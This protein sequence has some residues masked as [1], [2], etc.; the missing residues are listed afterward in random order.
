[1]WPRTAKLAEG[2]LLGKR[3]ALSRAI[4]LVESTRPDHR[5]Q[6]E[7]LVDHVVSERR[8]KVAEGI[9]IGVAGPPGAGKSTFIEAL[10]DLVTGMG[11]R[12]AVIPYDPSSTRTGGSILGDKTRMTSLSTNRSAF[13]RPCPTSGVLGGVAE[14]THEISLLCQAAGFDI[15]V[16]ESVGLGQSELDIDDVVD[17]VLLV[18]PPANGDD[19]QGV[20]KGVME[21]ADAVVVN[22][23][24][25]A[26][27]P[28]ARHAAADLKGALH[29]QRRKHP[30]W[31]P[32]VLLASSKDRTGID[33]VLD[34]ALA[35]SA[36]RGGGGAASGIAEHRAGQASRAL[37][38]SFA[39][40]METAARREPSVARLVE[41]LEAQVSAGHRT[42]RAAAS[43]VVLALIDAFRKV[44]AAR[45][46]AADLTK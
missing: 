30:G 11:R 2:V 21:I 34:V 9:R 4:T 1:M 41:H 15:V 46:R 32:K 45:G 5:Q 13:I 8:Q 14:A 44:E 28:A 6:G 29:F 22:K 35:F 43:D 3:R 40:Q 27:L 39:R 33:E 10:G 38:R 7:L 19:L 17:M 12:V 26:L 24:D 20:K 31:T 23:A 18:V 25:G 42:P 37:W 36:A 16:V